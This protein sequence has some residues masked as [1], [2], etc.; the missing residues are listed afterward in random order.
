MIQA[1]ELRKVFYPARQAPVVAVAGASFHV[2][3]GEVLGMLGPNGAGKTTLLRLMA[4]IV[5][6]TTG[7][8]RVNE[9]TVTEA[10]QS[11]RRG[12]GFLSGNTKLYGRLT[13]RETLHYFGQLYGM[14][15]TA[16][17]GRTEV[18]CDM[19]DMTA[20][21]DRRCD[22]LS[23]GQMQRVSIARCIVHDPHTLILDEPTLGLDI[24]SSR[25]IL[26][27]IGDARTRGRSVVF[28]THYMAE[29][30]RL[31]DRIA[32]LHRGVLLAVDTL[33]A[34]LERTRTA[35]LQD[36]FLALV[37]AEGPAP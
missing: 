4:A 11:V 36:T 3:D 2:G 30:E 16:I 35:N 1:D 13:P 25:T 32:L 27:F 8:C 34:L 22:T 20:F 18:L 9:H 7:Q 37:A 15:E 19:L 24:M 5:P 31:C 23:A 29:A 33:P 26:D 21:L 14:K 6:P 28:S 10:P 12:I 17:A